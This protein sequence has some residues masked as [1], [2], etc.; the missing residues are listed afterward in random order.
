L[1]NITYFD[2]S[3]VSSIVV[4]DMTISLSP[5]FLPLQNITYFDASLVS[6]IVVEDM[7]ISL[8]PS[9]LPSL[10]CKILLILMLPLLALLLLRI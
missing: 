1:Q 4:E 3:L 9:F 5:S 7:T 2:A 10:L 6:S 8:S